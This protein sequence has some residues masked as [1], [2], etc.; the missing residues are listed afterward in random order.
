VRYVL[1]ST[2][3]TALGGEAVPRAHGRANLGLTKR[4]HTMRV[5]YVRVYQR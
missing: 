3:D 5:D 1:I 4:P 2:K